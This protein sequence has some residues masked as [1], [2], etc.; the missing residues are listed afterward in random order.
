MTAGAAA[1]DL[2]TLV[3]TIE[4][5]S[6]ARSIEDV[7]EVVRSQARRIS[8]ADGV[9]FVLRDGDFCHY[10]DEDA[11][12]PLWKGK[13]F[14]IETCISGWAM[15]NGKTAVVPDIYLDDRIPHDAYRPTFVK[16][17]VMTPVRP[18]DPIASIGA[19]WK[20]VREPDP[21]ELASLQA[22]ARATATALENVRLLG[23]LN[24]ALEKREQMILEL[25]H[26]VK[27]T[28]A[29]ALSIA[30]QT[31]GAAP[32]PAAFTE[33]FNGRLMALSRAHEML[34]RE[35]WT[36]GDLR[37]ALT[38]AVGADSAASLT[39]D[40]PAV[41]LAPETAVSFIVVFH[42]LAMNARRFGALSVPS[43]QVCIDWS[44]DGGAFDLVWLE[45]G[46]PTVQA[47]RERG[48]GSKLIERGL[49]R[50]VSGTGRLAF[51]REGVRYELH[52][53]LSERVSPA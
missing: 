29:A 4:Q 21:A 17:L 7:A 37:E 15:L 13:R 10:L 48:F 12:G 36:G 39:L 3:E 19:Y 23:T 8:G 53:P 16:S 41:R 51:E 11:V 28:L 49:P 18:S 30:N 34:Q 35:D 6:A 43:G 45:R 32:S 25:D 14:P 52:A 40:G 46:G 50:D 27:N 9:T 42:E 26:R 1:T 38:L 2:L 20:D 5:L 44:T 47:P 24:E 22:I 33:A 31:L